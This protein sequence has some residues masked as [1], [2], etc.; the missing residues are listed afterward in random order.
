MPEMPAYE[1]LVGRIKDLKA[2]IETFHSLFDHS[3][4]A[5]LL[6][7]PNGEIIYANKD[8]CRLFQR[9]EQ[10][11]IAGGRAML[12]DESDPRLS[13]AIEERR[14]TGCF[15]GELNFKKADGT[16]FPGIISSTLFID[17]DGQTRTSIIIRDVTAQKQA[18]EALQKNE[19]FLRLVIDSSP[20]CIFVKDREGKYILVNDAISR[21]YGIPKDQI[22]NRTDLELVGNSSLSREE[23][24]RFMAE[25][26]IV[27]RKKQPKHIP[28]ELVA[29][30]DGKIRWFQTIK[31]PLF[32]D[33]MPDC[34]LGIAV[35]ITERK[36]A[37]QALRESEEQFSA[38]LE[39]AP[40]GVYMSDLEGHFLY[41][42]T[43]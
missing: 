15:C 23:A 28:E 41:G 21:L 4:C 32:S 12:V 14:R 8:T 38:Y 2:Q 33:S 17:T 36:L 1:D 37:E 35:D 29:T 18:E 5:I 27:I 11:I 19:K 7:N 13:L 10:E 16:I 40:D 42:K 26:Q 34:I 31:I 43:L 9:T 25:D 6:T 24:E 22:L 30:A 3:A 20:E 39:H